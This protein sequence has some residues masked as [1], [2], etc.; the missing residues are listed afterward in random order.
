MVYLR[1]YPKLPA[2]FNASTDPNH[3]IDSAFL[4][5]LVT[6]QVASGAGL[7]TTGLNSSFSRTVVLP[8]ATS[9]IFYGVLLDN[10]TAY[11]PKDPYGVTVNYQFG[12]QLVL[13]MT[14]GIVTVTTTTAVAINDPVYLDTTAGSAR[15]TF[16]NNNTG[17][18]G[19]L[20]PG[21]RWHSTLASA[22]VAELELRY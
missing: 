15:G 12:Q 13:V 16:R 22:G 5:E 18:V 7:V 2:G 14:R 19:I 17:S 3:N 21:A 20:V 9:D 10:P 11:R 6:T 8:T 1:Q 4:N